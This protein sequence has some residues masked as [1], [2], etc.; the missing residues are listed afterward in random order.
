MPCIQSLSCTAPL[1]LAFAFASPRHRQRAPSTRSPSR[2]IPS[3]RPSSP[4]ARSSF[5]KPPQRVHRAPASL[6]VRASLDAI[7]HSYSLGVAAHL[8]PPGQ[9]PLRG[10]FAH[11]RAGVSDS[12]ACSHSSSFFRL[13]EYI[14]RTYL[15]PRA[16][17]NEAQRHVSILLYEVKICEETHLNWIDYMLTTQ[18]MK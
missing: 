17:P 18:D 6:G 12:V 11:T 9:D 8:V 10:A 15:H 5:P 14:L 16:V 7:A 1:P 4:P 13:T 3:F 2:R